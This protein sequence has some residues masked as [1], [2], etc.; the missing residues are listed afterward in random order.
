MAKLTG[1][2]G[3][4]L[5]LEPLRYQFP[6]AANDWDANWLVIRMS[7]N[8]GKRRWT[9]YDPA[10]LTWDVYRLI[11]WLRSIARHDKHAKPEIG[12]TEPNVSFKSSW[13]G[14]RLTVKAA[15]T[16]EFRPPGSTHVWDVGVLTFQPSVV[17]VQEFARGLERAMKALPI[18]V[19]ES[20]AVA[21]ECVRKYGGKP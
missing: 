2:D 10:L 16:Q 4:M 12:F 20:G 11:Q 9:A 17:A 1:P 6:T 13:A 14:E 15:L 7:A 21:E 8:D 5:D 19:V 3:R 18:R